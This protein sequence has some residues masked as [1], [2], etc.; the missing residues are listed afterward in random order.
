MSVLNVGCGHKIMSG[1]VNLDMHAKNGADVVFDLNAIYDGK[2]LPFP[3]RCFDVVYC[4][5]V[6]EDFIDPVPVLT[7]LLRVTKKYLRVIV[8]SHSMVWLVNLYHK[9]GYTISSLRSFAGVHLQYGTVTDCRVLYAR[10]AN[11]KRAGWYVD[12]SVW[13]RNLVGWRM[14]E[15]TFLQYVFPMA[16]IDI[17]YERVGGSV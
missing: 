9:R 12:F 10:Y 15:Y 3:D 11:T 7:E 5:H 17:V 1:A 13:L 8:P 6:M 2:K 16:E 14:V 4:S